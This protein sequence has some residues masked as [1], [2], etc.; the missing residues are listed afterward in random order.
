[1]TNNQ[2][3]HLGYCAASLDGDV[4]GAV[5]AD[6]DLGEDNRRCLLCSDL[7]DQREDVSR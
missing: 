7:A 4:E 5:L 1:M 2:R 6:L 3:V